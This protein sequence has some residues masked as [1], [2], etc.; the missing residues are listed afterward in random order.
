MGKTFRSPT[1]WGS[2]RYAVVVGTVPRKVGEE[3]AEVVFNCW[4]GRTRILV[5]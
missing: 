2:E 5:I 1:R 3:A 4:T